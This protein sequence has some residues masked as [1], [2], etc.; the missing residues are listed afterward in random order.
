M[1]FNSGFKVLNSQGESSSE[2]V[3]GHCIS[4]KVVRLENIR[5]IVIF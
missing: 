2:W 3:S 1:G 5:K 4:V